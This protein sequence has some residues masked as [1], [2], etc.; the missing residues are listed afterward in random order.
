[1]GEGGP[2]VIRLLC[3]PA[4]PLLVLVAEFLGEGA[5]V[6]EIDV[7]HKLS[8]RVLTYRLAKA[9]RN[10]IREVAPVTFPEEAKRLDS[11]PDT[12]VFEVA[13]SKE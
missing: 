3:R 6:V 12:D 9:F 7:H 5:L 4:P 2:L 11:L 13:K 8:S 10:R 1:M